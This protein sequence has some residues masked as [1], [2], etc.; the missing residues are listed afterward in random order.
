MSRQHILMLQNYK[1]MFK[2]YLEMRA[3]EQSH[4]TETKCQNSFL[5]EA[6]KNNMLKATS[7]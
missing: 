7:S 1:I 3:I 6:L 4:A 5:Y 2:Q